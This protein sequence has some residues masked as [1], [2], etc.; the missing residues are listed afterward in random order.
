MVKTLCLVATSLGCNIVKCIVP[1]ETP[2]S[3]HGRDTG[4]VS[5]FLFTLSAGSGYIPRDKEQNESMDLHFGGDDRP[6]RVFSRGSHA[7]EQLINSIEHINWTEQDTQ[8]YPS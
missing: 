8:S 4:Y 6:C 5:D 2:A 3:V 1:G 7:M